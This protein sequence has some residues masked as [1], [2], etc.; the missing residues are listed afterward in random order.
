[1]RLLI[2]INTR[3]QSIGIGPAHL[4]A[5]NRTSGVPRANF[6][7]SRSRQAALEC[8][9]QCE[10]HHQ[11]GEC[12]TDDRPETEDNKR[13]WIIGS[14]PYHYWAGGPRRPVVA[15]CRDHCATSA[16]N[17]DLTASNTVFSLIRCDVAHRLGRLSCDRVGGLA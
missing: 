5:Q 12:G 16:G 2:S 1:V 11:C 10:P 15:F 8:A 7:M 17:S 4:A 6:R 9:A 13:I 14:L 3:A